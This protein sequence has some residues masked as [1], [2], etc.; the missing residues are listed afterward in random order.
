MTA[1]DSTLAALA[2]GAS[3]SGSLLAPGH[4]EIYAAAFAAPADKIVAGLRAAEAKIPWDCLREAALLRSA[5]APAAFLERRAAAARS[6]AGV[7]AAGWVAGVGDRHQGN[8]LVE[9]ATGRLVAI[10][11]G[12]SFGTALLVSFVQGRA[13]GTCWAC[14]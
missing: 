4:P 2:R 11:F 14:C 7:A 10:D 8:L 1:Y 6:A 5:A 9:D 13:L 12:Y 3:A